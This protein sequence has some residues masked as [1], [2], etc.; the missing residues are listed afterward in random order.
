MK[1]KARTISLALI[2]AML[3]VVLPT[4]VS[5]QSGVFED[6][7]D[8]DY[9]ARAVQWAV[10][11]GVTNGTSETTFSPELIC[12]RGQVVTFLWRAHGEPEPQTVGNPF[13]DYGQGYVFVYIQKGGL[14]FAAGCTHYTRKNITRYTE[15]FSYEIYA[16]IFFLIFKLCKLYHHCNKSAEKLLYPKALFDR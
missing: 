12:T 9:F 10:S 16:Y 15:I 13:C 7:S 3:L 14:S 1:L 4:T 2:I 5:A 6:V 11:W 8:S